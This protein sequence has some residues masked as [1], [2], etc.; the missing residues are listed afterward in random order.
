MND[1]LNY[2]RE[3]A[4]HF[5]DCV[6]SDQK[7]LTLGRLHNHCRVQ[8]EAI[9]NSAT[10]GT[11]VHKLENGGMLTVY[12]VPR[13]QHQYDETRYEVV[14]ERAISGTTHG[15]NHDVIDKQIKKLKLLL[16]T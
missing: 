13:S 16:L 12:P 5:I 1:F 2:S 6:L 8:A 10:Y 15:F 4:V 3:E 9:I 7:W 14:Y 11:V